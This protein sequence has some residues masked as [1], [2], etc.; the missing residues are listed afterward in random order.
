MEINRNNYEAYLL[1][2]FEGRLTDEE[3]KLVEEFLSRNPDCADAVDGMDRLVLPE[4]SLPFPYKQQLKKEMPGPDSIVS[5]K[6][7]DLFSIARL[8]GDLTWEQE[9]EHDQLLEERQDLREEWEGWKQTRL[10][11]PLIRFEGKRQLHRSTNT[12][13]RLVWLTVTSAAAAAA[14]VVMLFRWIP[15]SGDRVPEDMVPSP[16]FSQRTTETLIEPAPAGR[17]STLAQTEIESGSSGV[18][19]RPDGGSGLFSIQRNTDRRIPT[20]TTRQKGAGAER[21]DRAKAAPLKVKGERVARVSPL[22]GV[23][24]DR[25]EPLSIPPVTPHARRVILERITE[26][27]L[28]GMF[29]SYTEESEVSLW[30][31]ADLGIR[32]INRLTGAELSLMASRDEEGEIS[33][34]KLKAKRFSFSAPVD[35]PDNLLP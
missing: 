9:L 27:D 30:T 20:D 3:R 24:Y 34:I 15:F 35:R 16:D 33:G 22:Q 18:E 19:A 32:G 14:L 1:D 28:Q 25:I 4:E 26:V 29:E 2:L 8:E 11:A 17:P 23:I 31:I 10:K 5:A 21:D 13:S 6:H 12:R 7:F